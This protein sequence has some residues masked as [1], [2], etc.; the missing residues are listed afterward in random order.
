MEIV[1]NKEELEQ[2]IEME[3]DPSILKAIQDLLNHPSTSQLLQEKMISRALK[4]QEDI[5]TG[6]VYTKEEVI[7]RTNRLVG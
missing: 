3:D 2:K 5:V 1:V 4:A 6:R 7:A